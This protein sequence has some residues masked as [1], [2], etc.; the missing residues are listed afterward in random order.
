M[1]T[2]LQNFKSSS[3]T[4]IEL[5]FFMKKQKK[6]KMMKNLWKSYLLWSAKWDKNATR[7]HDVQQANAEHVS[8]KFVYSTCVQW[9]RFTFIQRIQ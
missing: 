1:E 9:T 5:R 3:A 6:M 8:S 4:V 2:G 7:A